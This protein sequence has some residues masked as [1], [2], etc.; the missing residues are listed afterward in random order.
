MNMGSSIS[1]KTLWQICVA[2]VAVGM[3]ILFYG[4]YLWLSAESQAKWPVA[5][6]KVYRSIAHRGRSY[7]RR[8]SSSNR[9]EVDYRYTVFGQSYEGGQRR[10]GLSLARNNPKGK[11]V[12][13]HY[14]PD[15]PSSSILEPPIFEGQA[16][17]WAGFVIC[18]GLPIAALV[19]SRQLNS[20][21]KP[22]SG[23]LVQNPRDQN[24]VLAWKQQN[25]MTT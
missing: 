22:S 15:N 18:I 24:E 25:G 10:S 1:E 13:I 3:A 4:L 9:S 5:Q 17:T 21:K 11:T 16:Y 7:S 19:L 6:G 23:G 14:D 2:G 20:G 8:R 12:S